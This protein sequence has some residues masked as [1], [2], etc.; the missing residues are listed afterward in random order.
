MR[1]AVESARL[2]VCGPASVS[3]AK[4]CAQLLVQVQRVFL[5]TSK[6]QHRPFYWHEQNAGDFKDKKRRVMIIY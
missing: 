6:T 4:V 1:V 5:W 3:E 2:S